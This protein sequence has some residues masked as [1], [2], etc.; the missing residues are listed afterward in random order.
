MI[1]TL[2]SI[3]WS[4]LHI[5]ALHEPLTVQCTGQAG[6]YTVCRVGHGRGRFL[7]KDNSVESTLPI[8]VNYLCAVQYATQ[9][10]GAQTLPYSTVNA[11]YLI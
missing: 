4:A 8:Y 1:K 9:N 6:H 10:K 7:G 5:C 11:Q 2:A 3:E